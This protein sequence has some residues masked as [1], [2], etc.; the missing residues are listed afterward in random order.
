VLLV[1]GQAVNFW[2]LYYQDRMEERK[3]LQFLDQL[4]AV[5]T[6]KN[7]RKVFAELKI[8]VGKLFSDLDSAT[9]PKL[10]AFREKRLPRMMPA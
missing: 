1:G 9:L 6:I 10:T 2:A 5:I 4:L 7:G 8:D 3:L